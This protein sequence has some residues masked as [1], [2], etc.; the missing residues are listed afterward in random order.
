MVL[1]GRELTPFSSA[2]AYETGPLAVTV[3]DLDDLV[4]AVEGLPADKLVVQA[5]IPGDGDLLGYGF[6]FA[7]DDE[8]W[9]PDSGERKGQQRHRHRYRGAKGDHRGIA[10]GEG[11]LWIPTRVPRSSTDRSRGLCAKTG[12][13]LSAT[14]EGVPPYSIE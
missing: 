3:L 8:P 11:A 2:K 7:L 9:P 10:M 1:K 6:D 12:I 13:D 5:E 4:F 14:C